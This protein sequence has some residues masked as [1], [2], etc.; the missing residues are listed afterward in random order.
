MLTLRGPGSPHEIAVLLRSDI[1]DSA[2]SCELAAEAERNG[3]FMLVFEKYYMRNSSRAS[4][5]VLI[6][7]ENGQTVVDAAASGGGQGSLF[8][9]DWGAGGD[10]EDTVRRI[11]VPLGFS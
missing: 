7:E 6:S 2:V 3:V 4:L 5:S 11:L 1:A 9:F 8:N 10:F